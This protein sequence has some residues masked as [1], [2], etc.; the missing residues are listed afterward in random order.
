MDSSVHTIESHQYLDHLG[1]WEHH[2]AIQPHDVEKEYCGPEKE[3]KA[4]INVQSSLHRQGVGPYVKN[5][6]KEVHN[7]V[8]ELEELNVNVQFGYIDTARNPAD[9]GTRGASAEELSSHIWWKAYPLRSMNEHDTTSSFFK[10]AIQDKAFEEEEKSNAFTV[11]A[12]TTKTEPPMDLLDLSRYSSKKKVLRILAYVIRFIKNVTVRLR[13]ALKNNLQRHLTYLHAPSQEHLTAS[14]IE[15]AHAVLIKNHQSV[16]LQQQYKKQLSKNLNL[17]E[18]EKH[19]VRAYGRLNKK[20][21]SKRADDEYAR[22]R[23]AE[24]EKL[25]ETI[26]YKRRRIKL[27][28]SYPSEE[29]IQKKISRI[30]STVIQLIRYNNIYESFTNI[31]G[32]RPQFFARMEATLYKCHMEKVHLETCHVLERLRSAVDGLSMGYELYGLLVL[33][34]DTLSTTRDEFFNQDIM[35]VPLD[36][37]F[38]SE[39]VRKEL[40]FL[41]DFRQKVEIEIREAELQ[42]KN[43]THES[44]SENLK[45]MI[46]DLQRKIEEKFEDL[47]QQEERMKHVSDQPSVEERIDHL[48]K[49]MKEQRE[50]IRSTCEK[51]DLLKDTFCKKE[52]LS[53]TSSSLEKSIPFMD[54]PQSTD[55]DH[56][57]LL[58]FD[59]TPEAVP[60]RD[61]DKQEDA[62]DS[63]T[64]VPEERHY[65]SNEED[66]LDL[67]DEVICEESDDEF[68]HERSRNDDS[69]NSQVSP[70]TK[71]AEKEREELQH[72]LYV[73]KTLTHKLRKV[74]ERKLSYNN[75]MREEERYLRCSFCFAK[76]MHY[77]DSCP[78]VPMVKEGRWRIRCESCL[79]YKH[80]IRDCWRTPKRCMYCSSNEHNK[81]L[82]ILPERIYDYYRE[83]E[84]IERELEAHKDYYGSKCGPST[85][86]RRECHRCDEV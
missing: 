64:P 32:N 45:R 38:T 76:G 29:E 67:H 24:E 68:M 46:T 86:T 15:D 69:N 50:E 37:T 21:A 19:L 83:I 49:E 44:V 40:E 63:K 9:I 4:L 48:S 72:R 20:M 30:L 53:S 42:T 78:E 23:R 26:R 17:K 18:D 13:E 31:R 8:K 47:G 10:I 85:H 82:C 54:Q 62:F 70:K 27:A 51:I 81:A 56:E 34:D 43:E 41:E 60:E 75:M 33:A 66:L 2:W 84:E 79:D 36:P 59:I 1:Q 55:D 12:T 16:Y 22:R 73:L 35:G 52:S 28:P 65:D 5:R 39:F 7:I 77:S 25:I 71:R 58:D 14:E 3:E 6:V 11:T 80:E 74:P 61:H 57:D